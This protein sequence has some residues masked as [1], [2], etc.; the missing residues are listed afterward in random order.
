[1]KIV[2][3]PYAIKERSKL[4]PKIRNP[5]T[6]VSF[7]KMLLNFRKPTGK[8]TYKIYDPL[9]VKLLVRLPLGFSHLSEQ[10]F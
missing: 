9:G 1:M 10:T 7:R 3:L 6:Y 8:S 5:E 4:E 2:F